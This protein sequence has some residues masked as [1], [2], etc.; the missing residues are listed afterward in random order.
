MINFQHKPVLLD[1]VISGLNIK[2]GGIYVDCTMGGGGHSSE[3]L[4]R[5]GSRGVLI[6]FDKDEDAIKTCKERF[7]EFDNVIIVKSDF[8]NA[9]KFLIENGYAK[10]IDGVLIDLGVS[11]YQIDTAERG[12]S[13]L[14]NGKLD[15][16]MDQSQELTAF[17]VVNTYSEKQLLKILY[18]YGEESNAKNIVK[19]ICKARQE[20]PIET[21]FELKEII[22][23]SFPKKIIYGKGGVSKKT[24]QAIRI[25]VNQEL[26]GLKKCIENLID[27]LNEKGRIAIVSFHSLE[28]RIVKNVFKDATTGCICPPKTPVCICK[29]KQICD[30]VTRKPITARQEELQKNS[31]S[32]SAKLRIVEK[33]W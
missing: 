13:F 14:H 11:S 3:I 17:T 23:K 32:S 33:I 4:K 15:M 22:E 25:E 7:K 19:N 26:E 29:H 30:M 27:L 8:K 9:Y 18:E 31:R 21:T 5:I 16:R 1:E 28:D 12:F 6:G 24:F 20:K 2:L 10:K